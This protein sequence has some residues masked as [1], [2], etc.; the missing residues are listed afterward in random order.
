MPLQQVQISTTMT[1]SPKGFGQKSPI[2]GSMGIITT[3]TCSQ[4][5]HSISTA[6]ASHQH[7]TKKLLER[8]PPMKF[9]LC[10]TVLGETVLSETVLGETLLG[11][12]PLINNVY[13]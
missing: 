2:M 12:E 1:N 13:T 6:S 10:E 9:M 11:E 3:K 7:S 5:F 4:E 8:K